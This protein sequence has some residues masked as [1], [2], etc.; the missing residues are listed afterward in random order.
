MT[1]QLIEAATSLNANYRA[2]CRGQSR[3]EFIAKIGQV[4]D[5][6]SE[7]RGWSEKLLDS[8][9]VPKDDELSWLVKE[10]DEL[11]R[12]FATAYRT[13]KDNREKRRDKKRSNRKGG[14]RRD[15]R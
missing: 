5:D 3:S 15:A 11:T 14:R 4:L 6:A 12:I 9:L 1:R 2:A 13:A 10:S 7:A 8:G